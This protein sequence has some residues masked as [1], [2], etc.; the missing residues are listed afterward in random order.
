MNFELTP[1]QRAIQ[2]LARELAEA[3]IAPHA[4][5]WDRAHRFPD[6]LYPKLA[7]L[8]LLGVC[9]PEEYGGLG[10]SL[11]TYALTVEDGTPLARRVER[12]E[13]PPPD[14][15]L[16]A[17]MYEAAESRLAAAGYRHYELSNWGR[18]GH[19]SRHNT[20]YWAGGD[21]LGLGAGAHAFLEGERYENV[22]HPREYIARLAQDF[23]PGEHPAVLHSYRS[24]PPLAAVDWVE[25][26]LRLV[27][28]FRWSSFPFEGAI[29]FTTAALLDDA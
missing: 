15:D 5:E 9:V 13:T 3:E 24:P 18:P 23:T 21:Y 2:T 11:L 8:G 27:D 16:A 17:A 4:G 1:E 10:E 20:V 12:G 25:S 7:E 19:E 6:E 22:A 28:G 26:H 14:P 29:R